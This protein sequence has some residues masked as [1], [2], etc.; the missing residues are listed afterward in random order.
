MPVKN[1]AISGLIYT[2]DPTFGNGGVGYI[3]DSSGT[4]YFFH[5]RYVR[6]LSR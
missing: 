4:E 2:L 1:R 3:K 5:S 6:R